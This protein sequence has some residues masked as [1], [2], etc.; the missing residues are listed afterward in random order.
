MQETTRRSAT[1]WAWCFLA[2]TTPLFA[3]EAPTNPDPPLDR[4]TQ[5]TAAAVEQAEPRIEA[6][7]TSDLTRGSQAQR[8]ALARQMIDAARGDTQDPVMRYAMWRLASLTAARAEDNSTAIEALGLMLDRFEIT[9]HTPIFEVLRLLVR[10]IEDSDHVLALIE[11][12]ADGVAATLIQG[13]LR[14]MTSYAQYAETAKRRVTSR[15]L[16][17]IANRHAEAIDES[18]ALL[19]RVNRAEVV[20]RRVSDNAVALRLLGLYE[21]LVRQDPEAASGY[22]QEMSDPTLAPILSAWADPDTADAIALG[23]AWL[24]L[25]ESEQGMLRVRASRRAAEQL[26]RAIGSAT[27]LDRI[28]VEQQ[29]AEAHRLAGLPAGYSRLTV[30]ERDRLV[31]YGDKW[32]LLVRERSNH[33]TASAWAAERGATLVSITSPAQNRFLTRLATESGVAKKGFWAGGSDQQREGLWRWDDGSPWRYANWG[34]R[35]PDGNDPAK[36]Q[37]FL[38]VRRNG[39]WEDTAASDNLVFFVQWDTTQ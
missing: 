16:L 1:V 36:P 10:Q 20:Y 11:F 3:D 24:E 34:R 27:G 7:F 19:Q 22:W 31:Q 30:E 37:N 33:D 12:C 35:Q 15:D 25:A 38:K 32:L 14:A 17:P 9:D 29:L 8:A 28:A 4:L 26:E 6:V 13:D 18:R 5:P 23:Q 39:E 21:A 2:L